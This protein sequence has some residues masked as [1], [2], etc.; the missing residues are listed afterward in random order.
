MRTD[1]LGLAGVLV[2][3][4]CLLAQAARETG[5]AA[6]LEEKQSH[7]TPSLRAV[8]AALGE[9][10]AADVDRA[11]GESALVFSPER[12]AAALQDLSCEAVGAWQTVRRATNL[13]CGNVYRIEYQN[14]ELLE[15][16]A[17]LRFAA[18]STVH[19]YL[20]VH[21][22]PSNET[23]Q[24]F[25]RVTGDCEL[26]EAQGFGVRVH[27][28]CPLPTPLTLHL[29]YDYAI[30][31]SWAAATGPGEDRVEYA[32]DD[33]LF[34]QDFL[35]GQVMERVMY[36]GT[37]PMQDKVE[38]G[39]TASVGACSFELC[40][41]PVPGACCVPPDSPGG[42]GC[43]EK[44]SADCTDPRGHFLGEQSQCNDGL[45][46][47]GACCFPCGECDD[48]YAR[49]AC[50]KPEQ[51]GT[52]AGA[53]VTCPA[54]EPTDLCPVITGAC[55]M[56]SACSEICIDQ[57]EENEGTYLG[58]ETTCFP[59]ECAGACCVPDSGCTDLTPDVCFLLGGS[60]V[61]SGTTCAALPPEQECGGACCAK[62]FGDPVCFNVA[63]RGECKEQP[64][65]LTATCYL[66]DAFNCD[67]GQT[68]DCADPPGCTA[69]CYP[70]GSCLVSTP[71]ACERAMGFPTGELS[72]EGMTC[73]TSCCVA[74]TE[75]DPSGCRM[76]PSPDDCTNDP[77]GAGGEESP[78]PADSCVPDPC[79]AIIGA[80]C[81][82][83]GFGD[84]DGN[85]ILEL[86]DY[87]QWPTCATGPGGPFASGCGV[88]DFQTD[89]DV[90]LADFGRF[91]KDFG[92]ST[93]AGCSPD[94]VPATCTAAGGR[95]VE[96]DCAACPAE[97]MGACCRPN[98]T[99]TDLVT[100]VECSTLGGIHDEDFHLG[101]DCES[102]EVD[103]PPLGACCTREGICLP[104]KL[105]SECEGLDGSFA[106]EGVLCG[107]AT[108]PTG[109]CCTGSNCEEI[110]RD[111]CGVAGGTYEG[112]GTDCG[113][114]DCPNVLGAC[115]LGNGLCDNL[116]PSVCEDAVGVYQGP[117][118]S[119]EEDLCAVGAC[120]L[121]DDPCTEQLVASQC[122]N[123][124]GEFYEGTLC[125][126]PGICDPTGACCNGGLCEIKAE[127]NCA[128]PGD[129]YQRDGTQCDGLCTLGACCHSDGT[130]DEN[131]VASQCEDPAVFHT[132][133]TCDEVECLGNGA[134]C[135]RSGVCEE[136]YSAPA[137]V[138][139]GGDFTPDGDCDLIQIEC[140]PRGAC[141]NNGVCTTE[142]ESACD[143][144]GGLYE[145][146]EQEC[147][148]ARCT[149]G[150]CCE[151][152][153]TT[154]TDDRVASQCD[155]M[156]RPG[157]TCDQGPSCNQAG[158][159][160]LRDGGCVDDV[161]PATCALNEGELTVDTLCDSVPCVA[162][163]ACCDDLGTC[164][165]ESEDTCVSSGGV[166]QGADTAC[167]PGLCVIGAC[168]TDGNQCTEMTE[169]GCAGA[170]GGYLGDGEECTIG[171]CVQGACCHLDGTCDG[172]AVASE[173]T[174]P[175]DEFSPF[176]E[177]SL[178]CP[179][180]RGA[181]CL[182][183]FTCQDA[184][185][186]AQCV[187]EEPRGVYDGD[188]TVCR[189]GL[190]EI[191][192]CCRP[193]DDPACEDVTTG[194]D[195]EIS[196]GVYQGAG[197]F[198]EVNLCTA[199]SCCATDG[200]CTDDVVPSQCEDPDVFRPEQTCAQEECVGRGACCVPGQSCSIMRSTACFGGGRTYGGDATTCTPDDLCDVGACC[201]FD[202]TC[203]MQTRMLCERQNGIYL[204]TEVDCEVDAVDCTRGACCEVD[205]SCRDDI[206]ESSCGAS[207][208]RFDANLT[209]GESTCELRGACCKSG[210]CTV[211]TRVECVATEGTY[212]GPGVLCEPDPCGSISITSSD[213]PDCA[214]DARQPTDTEGVTVY[215]WDLIELTFDADASAL[216]VDDFTVEVL[217]GPCDLPCEVPSIVS[218]E[219]VGNIAMLE[220]SPPIPAGWWTCITHIDSQTG[221]CL[222]F[223][224]GDVDESGTSEGADVSYLT[225]CLDGTESCEL[226]QCDLDQS[227]LC[228][229]EDILRCIDLLNGAEPYG[230][231]LD[232][233][234]P[235]CP[236][237][238][239]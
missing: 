186:E 7:D 210:G 99:C 185:P 74:A 26:P 215:G 174:E 162:I 216:T 144:A 173:C 64:P 51:G 63:E 109:V 180:P 89:G 229:P 137:C 138:E 91:Q 48:G 154:C 145:G 17:Q 126:E 190:C 11:E 55:C 135:L 83:S 20:S 36:V 191:G 85:G 23:P 69:C 75:E 116:L 90:D 136:G 31:V 110:T 148:L 61:G 38:F 199:G 213:P 221:P 202:G 212:Q 224:P 127:V 219:T 88:L 80:C 167:T 189:P 27:Y 35:H 40:F 114:I 226:W 12:D 235:F 203:A 98:G 159:C 117:Y 209:C 16:S 66:G 108:C 193:G 72:C 25:E 105:A 178:T 9:V 118:T 157:I 81:F 95:F 106:G 24:N 21:R 184:L 19:L 22:A 217:P 107:P 57:C 214:I 104:D 151:L 86:D 10:V 44:L 102:R 175:F 220:L 62:L 181:C 73:S 30:G 236:N 134:C 70:D 139:V 119:C 222:G 28:S 168:C 182:P 147:T 200:T 97:P 123:R 141:C 96:G 188:G 204:G 158:A 15:I 111:A 77:P 171:L 140:V 231:W 79:E 196:G 150:S 56:G 49:E 45:C 128:Q 34:P 164:T 160:C 53:N 125:D 94:I 3:L 195:C 163:G 232:R 121:P 84:Y 93:D 32:Y 129:V 155:G 41:E 113:Q 227:G 234:L 2:V 207:G 197:A 228:A 6:P 5:A 78:L 194:Q 201:R 206:L 1:R 172:T 130:C 156:F 71:D 101:E 13:Y 65:D 50:E 146:D 46:S 218:L 187:D 131:F 239:P 149:L 67:G 142:A 42:P 60:F 132:E 223:L 43:V 92:G 237:G 179:A 47:F 120:C 161:L 87:K 192:A 8:D 54:D 39:L 14:A 112:D 233:S 153:G 177:C 198:C 103:C 82:T 166:F 165:E 68:P 133:Q 124:G 183:D 205:G 4:G 152:D 238:Q 58:D 18:N 169:V 230:P 208:S 76:T 29:G 115:C 33:V 176:D 100:A 211:E 143:S 170:G 122:T 37:P 59:N 225:A 52:W